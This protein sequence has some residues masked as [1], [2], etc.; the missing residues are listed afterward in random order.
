MKKEEAVETIL[1]GTDAS[2]AATLAVEQAAVLARA[3]DAELVI[4]SVRPPVDPR[5]VFD[6][7]GRPH[8]DAHLGATS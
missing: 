6:P 1:V 2:P 4:L 3:H 5:E 8:V 7:A